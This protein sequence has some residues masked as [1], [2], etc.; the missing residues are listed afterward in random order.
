MRWQ[1]SGRNDLSSSRTSGRPALT[2]TG[3]P[4]EA[5]T[6]AT[7]NA[8]AFIIGVIAMWIID[9]VVGRLMML[10]KSFDKE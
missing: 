3:M 10:V 5:A 7:N 8:A 2:C 1:A 4:Q 6:D 9:I